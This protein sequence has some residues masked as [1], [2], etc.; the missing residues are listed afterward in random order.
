[1]NS[2]RIEELTNR[3]LDKKAEAAKAN[4]EARELERELVNAILDTPAAKHFL[5]ISYTRLCRA[6]ALEPL[7]S[8]IIN[9]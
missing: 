9:H 6:F 4:A 8:R 2:E 1:M 3:V 7:K 5:S